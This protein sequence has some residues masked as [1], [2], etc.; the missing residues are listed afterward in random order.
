M[1]TAR[2]VEKSDH[3]PEQNTTDRRNLNWAIIGTGTIS[4]SVVPDFRLCDGVQLSVVYSR[5]PSKAAHF[6]AEF[7]IPRSTADYKE[8][9]ADPSIDALY[10][11]TPFATHHRMTMDALNAGKHVLVEKPMAWSSVE[12]AELFEAA[13]SKGVFLMEAM[14]LKFNRAFERLHDE[15]RQG[16]I[17]EPRNMRAAFSAPHADDDGSRWD[18]NRSGSTL[19]DQG[20]YPV[21]LAHSI[22][23]PPMSVHAVGTVRP[24]GVDLGEHFTLE[25]DNGRF[26]QCVSGMTEF[27]DPSAAVSGTKGWISVPAPFW[28]M[29]E[30]EI[31]A[32]SAEGYGKS[33]PTVPA[34]GNGYVPML[35]EVNSAILRGDTQHP[36]HAAKD[37]LEVF[38]TLDEIRR[39]I[40]PPAPIRWVVT[41]ETR[42]WAEHNAPALGDV[43][44][45]PDIFLQ[46]DAPQQEIE[47][48]GASFNELG[49][50]SLASLTEAQRDNIMHELFA[51]GVGA[52]LTLC[53]MPIGANDFSRDWY[54]YDETD[55]DF[56]LAHFSIANDLETL[57]P[58]I[59]AAQ[60]H[61]PELRLWAS[62]WSPPTWMKTNK[63]YAGALPIAAFSDVQNGLEP[64]QAGQEGTD[65]FV[66]TH[67]YLSAYAS[68]FG[69]FVD[70]YRELGI[71]IGMVMPQNEFNSP[72]VFPS[73]TWTPDGLARFIALLGPE[74]AARD[75]E[76]FI[77]TLERADDKLISRIMD[78]P[79][80]ARWVR[81]VGTQWH[82]KNAAP[83]INH[84]RPE[85]R[86][87]Q[88]EQECG[89][90][91]NDW[92]YARYAWGQLKH[93][94]SNGATAYMYWNM[95]LER[96]GLS[97]WGWA[98]NS[99]L[100]VDVEAE[101]YSWNHEYHLFK[102]VSHFVQ[103]GARVIPTLSYAG[104]ENQ[105]AFINP[106]GSV[107]IVI[108]NDS[109]HE[110]KPAILIGDRILCPTLPADSFSTF[111]I[112]KT[113]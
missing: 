105:L 103:A 29:T 5:D 56:A 54:S 113:S 69:R 96:G 78:D 7:E 48:F 37:T 63:H 16:T 6:A 26:A 43:T 75:V 67:E 64:H 80:A 21:T 32:P 45:V 19:L 8:V 60:K 81:G 82:G 44:A 90:G 3:I 57:V 35:R 24:D 11:A 55:G 46:L 59:R 23:G 109:A 91:A 14:W 102:H 71:P 106:D 62:P 93:Y 27:S 95:A 15:I 108:H 101:T 50:T 77:G 1:S 98:Q 72:Q 104:Y 99:F 36:A 66:Q 20:I 73:C 58:F 2:A 110:Q 28:S 70:A 68:Y 86:I 10:I 89:D 25:F 52:N 111:L 13:A 17:G 18:I 87:Y 47:G 4:R 31:I 42:Q 22:F 51:P 74:M 84:D 92:R 30:M 12:V 49:W 79:K 76:V 83:F 88:T 33:N 65:M 39:Q 112:P 107:V 61:Q 85:L 34:E 9:L 38:A 53:R 100:T 94:I 40:D 41:T 97:R